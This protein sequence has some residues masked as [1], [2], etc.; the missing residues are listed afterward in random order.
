MGNN[1]NLTYVNAHNIDRISKMN[2][3]TTEDVVNKIL[4][5]LFSDTSGIGSDIRTLC[6]N[7]LCKQIDENIEILARDLQNRE[8]CSVLKGMIETLEKERA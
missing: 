2:G 3:R 5:I 8:N 6:E 7:N 4:Y 1:I